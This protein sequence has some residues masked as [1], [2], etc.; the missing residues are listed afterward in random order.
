MAKIT[1]VG[2]AIAITSALKLEEVKILKKYR[3][4]AL[5][6]KD[7]NDEPIFMIS[8]GNSEIGEYGISFD[9]ATADG[10]A[11]VTAALSYDGDDV[12]GYVLDL[13]GGAVSKL[14]K[15]E[16]I[17]PDVLAE[18]NAEREALAASVTVF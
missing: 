10:N 12:Q 16:A 11:V 8:T 5:T 7:E 17:L 1:V 15:L 2:K 13:V 4:S 9:S 14:N 3:P 18:V 6:L